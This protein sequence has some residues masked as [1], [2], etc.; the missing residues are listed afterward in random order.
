MRRI[1]NLEESLS[2]I[3]RPCHP[4]SH[5]GCAARAAPIAVAAGVA[6]ADVWGG[7]DAR[8]RD[9]VVV[10]VFGDAGLE[11]A[12]LIDQEGI[13]IVRKLLG[14]ALVAG[15]VVGIKKYLDNNPE[16]KRQVKEQA[17]RAMGQAKHLAEGAGEKV[18]AR[19]SQA[20]EKVDSFTDSGTPGS[21]SSTSS[22][23][24]PNDPARGAPTTL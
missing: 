15:I 21:T 9:Q 4:R 12:R 1:T 8:R 18:K 24:T 19:T 10:L 3:R 20:Q 13:G 22:A 11:I 14:L 7:G 5:I 16:A 2:R 23:T 17:N 6:T